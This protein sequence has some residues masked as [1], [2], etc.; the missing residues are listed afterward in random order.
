MRR[1]G[2]PAL[3]A[4]AGVIGGYVAVGPLAVPLVGFAVAALVFV[5]G[6]RTLIAGIGIASGLV[7]AEA[8][9]VIASVGPVD[10][11]FTDA[12]VVYV[13]AAAAVRGTK[14]ATMHPSVRALTLAMV[15]WGL[16]RTNFDPG[17]VSFIRVLE[18]LLLAWSLP[19]LVDERRMWSTAA[20]VGAAVVLTAPFVTVGDVLAVQ[21]H[22]DARLA[23]YAGGPNQLGSIAAMLLLVGW[24]RTG[25]RRWALLGVGALG[26]FYCRSISSMVAAALGLLVV[27]GL[28]GS[29]LR[30]ARPFAPLLAVIGAV[31][32]VVFG[33]R[34]RSD[35]GQTLHIHA[36]L[37]SATGGVLEAVNPFV[38]AGWQRLPVG[39]TSI[40]SL[41]ALYLD[42]LAY[43]GGVG[44]LLLIAWMVALFRR[45]GSPVSRA[46]VVM[47]GVWFLTTGAFPCPAW[48]LLGLV[49]ATTRTVAPGAELALQQV[50]RESDRNH[51]GGAGGGGCDADLDDAPGR[52]E[53]HQARARENVGLRVRR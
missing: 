35:A 5:I 34:L 3:I 16:V 4:A 8:L 41:H 17:V 13:A 43:L 40:N 28:S 53:G 39:L 1:L 22:G 51:L 14:P 30:R 23:G 27:Q 46:V 25:L 52:S 33:P 49:L 50:A 11:R 18:P 7:V 38:G 15:G 44:L 6:P 42:W 21:N 47:V 19:R 32:V 2:W 31:A 48:A 29:T 9:P 24:L 45:A 12:A 26:L 10:L 20:V 36:N 37:A